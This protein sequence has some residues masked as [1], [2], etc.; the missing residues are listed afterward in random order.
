MNFIRI[1][2][3]IRTYVQLCG[4]Y[5]LLLVRMVLGCEIIFLAFQ[6]LRHDLSCHLVHTT[7][8]WYLDSLPYPQCPT[9]SKL[10]NNTKYPY[11]GKF[12]EYHGIRDIILHTNLMVRFS[13]R[14][15]CWKAE[16]L[17]YLN[18]REIAYGPNLQIFHVTKISCFTVKGSSFSSPLPVTF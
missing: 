9:P 3:R 8:R 18:I 4:Q 12:R 10:L 13:I 16:N 11:A 1:F 17:P 14:N 6:G 7:S 15:H 5:G 2:P